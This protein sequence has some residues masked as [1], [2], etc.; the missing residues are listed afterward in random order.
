VLQDFGEAG[1]QAIEQLASAARDI[2][3][4]TPSPFRRPSVRALRALRQLMPL[5]LNPFHQSARL[6]RQRRSC[7]SPT[8]PRSSTNAGGKPQRR[9]LA[10]G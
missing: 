9:V 6:S 2:H 10:S 8:L 1:S 3:Q 7:A 4:S 5:G